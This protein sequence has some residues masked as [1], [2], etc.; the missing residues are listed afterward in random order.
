MF[1]LWK[2]YLKINDTPPLPPSHPN[3]PIERVYFGVLSKYI[4]IPSLYAME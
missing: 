3:T 4:R 2:L 1:A